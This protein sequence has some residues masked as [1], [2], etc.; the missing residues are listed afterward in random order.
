[1]RF[2]VGD[3]IIKKE[4]YRINSKEK[5]NVIKIIKILEYRRRSLI[6]LSNKTKS[7]YIS[8]EMY[9]LATEKEIKEQK[10]KKIFQL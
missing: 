9:R 1:M 2:K 3:W 6:Y 7:Y 8:L 10:I 5:T 4:E